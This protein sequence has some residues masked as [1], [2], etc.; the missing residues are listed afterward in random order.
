MFQSGVSLYYSRYG[1]TYDSIKC[2][3]ARHTRDIFSGPRSKSLPSFCSLAPAKPTPDSKTR[4][5]ARGRSLGS[6]ASIFWCRVFF[7]NIRYDSGEHS[8]W[9]VKR[10][11]T[12]RKGKAGPSCSSDCRA[13]KYFLPVHLLPCT[14]MPQFAL[15]QRRGSQRV[16]VPI[17][18]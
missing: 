5:G 14:S 9:P 2:K 3:T 8:L 18:V 1:G 15:L 6:T 16:Y 4:W 12:R 11:T 17:E 7:P 13:K 10:P